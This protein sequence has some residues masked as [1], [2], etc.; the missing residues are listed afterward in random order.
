M[1]ET[2]SFVLLAVLIG[3]SGLFSGIETAVYS[4][5]T[6]HARTFL[7]NRRIGAEAL[8]RLKQNP[9]KFIITILLANN[10]VNI[11]AA[12][13]A[14]SIAIGIWGS[15]GVGIATGI[16]TFLILV[17]GEI[18]PKNIAS[19]HAGAISLR[20]AP[21]ILFVQ[22]IFLPLIWIFEFMTRFFMKLFKLEKKPH[23]VTEEELKT[24]FELGVEHDILEKEERELLEGVLEFNDITAK[25][26]M[27]PRA[28]VFTLPSHMAISHAIKKLNRTSFSRIPIYEDSTDHI[29]GI[30]HIRDILKA[31]EKK[32]TKN[33]LKSIANKPLFI[34][35]EMIISDVF[36]ELQRKSSQMAVV[37]DEHGTKLG[38]ATME[39]L[40]EEIVGEITDESD[41]SPELMKRISK[42]KIVVHGDTE[43]EEVNSFFGV[44]LP[45]KDRNTTIS[46]LLHKKLK[47]LPRVNSQIDID[48]LIFLRV[49]ETEKHVVTK[50]LIE[51][52]GVRSLSEKFL[53]S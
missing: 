44:D 34:S 12:G 24:M 30:V 51:K 20:I 15:A 52:K 53:K 5:S 11:W 31:V 10:I 8:V 22:K 49:L 17:F 19:A 18:A 23:V 43:I 35:Q 32:K 2:Q 37:L 47:R 27:T 26:V 25:E 45:H 36:K 46:K 48:N 29:T 7:K 40:L 38:I 6:V 1:I 3:L 50:V 39:D 9:R 41:V 16:M 33:P 4:V 28:R 42:N 13:L 21:F 14:T